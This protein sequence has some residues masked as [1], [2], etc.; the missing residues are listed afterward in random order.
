MPAQLPPL[1]NAPPSDP[2]GGAWLAQAFKLPWPEDLPVVSRMGG[3]RATQVT[4]NGWLET[5]PEAARPSADVVAH[6]LF[7]L[8]HEVPHLGLLARLF[9]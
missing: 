4:G 9:E 8:R 5:W 1:T 2:L 3:R 7:H 6:L